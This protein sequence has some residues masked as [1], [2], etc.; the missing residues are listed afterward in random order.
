MFVKS[1]TRQM[2]MEFSVI[3][4]YFVLH[5]KKESIQINHIH[6]HLSTRHHFSIKIILK[7]QH[8]QKEMMIQGQNKTK[9]TFQNRAEVIQKCFLISLNFFENAKT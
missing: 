9:E 7:Q 5:V 8:Q 1:E 2:L 3:F 6:T 4:V